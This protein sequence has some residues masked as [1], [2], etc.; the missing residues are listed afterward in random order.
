M[1]RL[2]GTFHRAHIDDVAKLHFAVQNLAVGFINLV[3][4]D[5]FDLRVDVFRD[6][7]IEHL[8]CFGNASDEGSGN[9]ALRHENQ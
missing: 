5:H 9:F 3:N 2:L 8:L 4:R 6:G 7:V 1:A